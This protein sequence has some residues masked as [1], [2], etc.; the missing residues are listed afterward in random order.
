M[1]Q[2]RGAGVLLGKTM[3]AAI[4]EAG[5]IMDLL[6]HWQYHKFNADAIGSRIQFLQSNDDLVIRTR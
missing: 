4:N 2:S 3:I 6:S 5:S 1:R